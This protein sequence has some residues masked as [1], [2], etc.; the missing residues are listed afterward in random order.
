M[1]VEHEACLNSMKGVAGSSVLLAETPG[2]VT[3][4]GGGIQTDR[5]LGRLLVQLRKQPVAGKLIA[6]CTKHDKEWR[7][8]RLSG[9]KGIPPAFADDR[10]FGDEHEV[11]HAIF[12]MRLEAMPTTR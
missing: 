9:V 3:S 4:V 1:I 12:L 6:V 2:D 11:Q 7:I 5:Q 10:V 8:A